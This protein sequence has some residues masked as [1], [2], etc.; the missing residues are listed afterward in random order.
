MEKLEENRYSKDSLE[1]I[2]RE[3]ERFRLPDMRD[4]TLLAAV[5]VSAVI[6]LG[7]VS[8]S[9]TSVRNITLL[10]CVLYVLATLVYRN[11]YTVN[12]EKGRKSR[13]Y[14]EA[15]AEYD[16]LRKYICEK[17]LVCRMS[18]FCAEYTATELKRYREGLLAEVNISYGEYEELYSRESVG[19]L[20]KKYSLSSR[21]IKA[22]LV[23]K[24]AK[25][26]K[27][28]K[29]MILLNDGDATFRE[30]ALVIS[31]KEKQSRDYRAN[32]VS[33]LLVTLLSGA[34]A[35]TF[36][37]EPTAECLV[38]WCVRMVPIVSAA[39]LGSNSG[40]L[41]G[42]ETASN[43]LRAQIIKIKEFLEWTKRKE[44]VE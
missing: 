6:S 10:V 20:R 32:V 7:E 19:A 1:Q 12:L 11:R 8:L 38:R 24:R 25:A 33:R 40:Y 27:L 23:C 2:K 18:E 16:A 41:N 42:S 15:Y 22:I 4:I 28:N 31:S 34:L 26:I 30:G 21:A 29:N 35:V 37:A 17:G 36:L 14:T 5:F 39:F 44:Q 9:L 43:Y 3:G 13:A